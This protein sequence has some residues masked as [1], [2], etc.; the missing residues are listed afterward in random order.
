MDAGD[1]S[2]L[3]GLEAVGRP[4]DG[5]RTPPTRR[6]LSDRLSSAAIA[7]LIQRFRAGETVMAL[8]GAFEISRTSVKK[9][10]RERGVRRRR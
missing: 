5:D 4:P 6:R 8:A 1:R 3:P 9:I 10:L 7:E 2:G